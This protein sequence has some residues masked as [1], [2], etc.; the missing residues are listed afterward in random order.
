MYLEIEEIVNKYDSIIDYVWIMD[1]I[2]G[3]DRKW[4]KEFC[5]KYKK[6]VQKKFLVLMRVEMI[7]EDLLIMLKEAGCS[8]IFFGVESGNETIRTKLMNRRM[9][10]QKIIDA[11]DLCH[12][13]SLETLAVNIIGM[14]GESVEMIWDTIHLNRR[15]RPTASG[16]NIFYPY[17]GTELGDKCFEDGLV[18]EELVKNFSLERRD[19]VLKFPEDHMNRLKYFSDNWQVLV[20]PYNVKYR[21]LK[22]LKQVGILESAIRIKR[23]LYHFIC[24][25]KK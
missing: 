9:S 17:R 14:P 20:Y 24:V 13:Y 16:V 1:D 15:L 23:L 8:K 10:N 22:F 12:K 5:E 19:T 3:L 18:D 21:L 6:R 11:F 7:N 4:R 25:V 2:F